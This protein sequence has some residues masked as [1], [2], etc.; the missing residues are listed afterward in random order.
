MSLFPR[1]EGDP[2]V[3]ERLI[4]KWIFERLDGGMDWIDLA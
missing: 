4:L 3:D 2:G 1:V